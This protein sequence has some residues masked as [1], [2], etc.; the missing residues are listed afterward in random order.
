[1]NLTE[2]QWDFIEPLIPKNERMSRA[3][4]GASW[5]NARELI[6]GVL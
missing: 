6:D 3:T 1:M 5:R 2:E 4:R